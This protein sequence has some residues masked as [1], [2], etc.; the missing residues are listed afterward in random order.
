MAQDSALEKLRQK[1]AQRRA[2]IVG[3]STAPAYAPDAAP[4]AAVEA[5]PAL[6]PRVMRPESANI[7]PPETADEARR[8]LDEMKRIECRRTGRC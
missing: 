1:S 2:D 3:R 7:S 8:V 4:N 5:V 6:E